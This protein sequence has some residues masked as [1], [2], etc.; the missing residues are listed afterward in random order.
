[1]RDESVVFGMGANLEFPAILP[2]FSA[3]LSEI[4]ESVD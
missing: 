4:F 2:G 3:S 1:M